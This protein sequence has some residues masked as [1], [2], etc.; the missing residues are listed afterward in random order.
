[1][2]T[3]ILINYLKLNNIQ[4]EKCWLYRV[5]NENTDYQLTQ[6]TKIDCLYDLT[7]LIVYK[8][9]IIISCRDTITIVESHLMFN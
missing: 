5:F 9:K 3:Q 4:E 8:N 7:D 2:K 6:R 1:M